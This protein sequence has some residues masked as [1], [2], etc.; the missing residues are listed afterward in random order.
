M[1]R[2]AIATSCALVLALAIAGCGSD[3]TE[4]PTGASSTA[5]TSQTPPKAIGLPLIV[6]SISK[7]ELIAKANERC[8]ESW[9]VMRREYARFEKNQGRQVAS[10]RLSKVTI[11]GH[12]QFWFDD[13]TYLGSPE[14]EKQELEDIFKALQLAVYV[15]QEE[16]RPSPALLTG[17]FGSFNRVAED[18]GLRGCIVNGSSPEAI[19]A[20]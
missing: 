14:G 5:A 3:S 18:Y 10:A 15:A 1:R 19:L 12:A 8:R 20:G 2:R 16:K 13:I 17:I 9:P 7:A 4:D 6:N 11:P